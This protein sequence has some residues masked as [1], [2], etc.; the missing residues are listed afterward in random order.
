M[1]EDIIFIDQFL[2]GDQKGFEMLVKKYQ[3]RVLNIVYSLIGVDSESED[4]TQEV[5]LK[6]YHHLKSFKRNCQ[7]STWVYRIVVNTTYDF[8]RKRKNFVDDNSVLEKCVSTADSPDDVFCKEE[9][10]EVISSALLKVPVNF[11]TA[12]VLKDIEG[13]SYD[14]IS[15]VLSCSIGTVE[16]KIYRARHFLKEVL[17]KDAGELI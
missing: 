15:K 12:L 6:V 5:F 16:S 8:L 1:D 13:L 4:I 2:N 7:F 14:D 11:R 9:R 10:R 17:R 3:N